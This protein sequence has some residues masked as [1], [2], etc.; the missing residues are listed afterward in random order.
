MSLPG[1]YLDRDGFATRTIAPSYLVDGSWIDPTGAFTDSV[2][3]QR[4]ADFFTFIEKQLVIATSKV[5]A[6]LRKRYEVPFASPAPE[7]VC[8]WIVSLV[9]PKVYRRRGVDTTDEQIASLDAEAA[10]ALDEIKEA[11]DSN[12]GLYDLPLRQD[13]TDTALSPSVGGPLSYSEPDAYIWTDVQ[14][15]ALKGLP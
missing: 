2:L 12:E 15:E 1:S 10:A 8:G 9:T 3:V 11:A 5:N 7:V 6:R 13:K 4:R 14:R